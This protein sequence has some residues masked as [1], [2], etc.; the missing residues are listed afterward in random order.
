MF[1]THVLR[2]VW[3]PQSEITLLAP[4]LR[5]RWSPNCHSYIAICLVSVTVSSPENFSLKLSISNGLYP[6]LLR[7]FFPSWSCPGPCGNSP[8]DWVVPSSKQ[9][10]QLSPRFVSTNW[11]NA[12]HWGLG[13]KQQCVSLFHSCQRS[14]VTFSWDSPPL[15]LSQP[16]LLT[17]SCLGKPDT[18]GSSLSAR[19]SPTR[20][21]RRTYIKP[22]RRRSGPGTLHT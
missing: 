19:S 6:E 18:K 7:T 8:T 11:T 15:G 13:W 2:I 5:V 10:L 21:S 14:P 9:R 3:G 12:E 4:W 22:G 1:S 17:I 20:A 16:R